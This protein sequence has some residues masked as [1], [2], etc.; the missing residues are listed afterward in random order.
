MGNYNPHAPYILGNEWVPIRQDDWQPD[1][2]SEFGYA[3]SI[4]HAVTPVTG[5]FYVNEVPQTRTNQA[6]DL[7]SVYPSGQ[8]TLT[9]P[10][11]VIHIPVS[12]VSSTGT[13]ISNVAVANLL[14]PSDGL[15][16]RFDTPS[17]GFTWLGLSF[18]VPAY[19]QQLYGKRILNVSFR[20]ALA[21]GVDAAESI[22]VEYGFAKGAFG[23]Q[24]NRFSLFEPLVVSSG[25]APLAIGK[26]DLTSINPFWD[27]S[28][29]PYQVHDVYP[30]RFQELSRFVFT[31]PPFSR[32]TIMMFNGLTG[33]SNAF[34]Y[35]ADLEVTYCEETRVLYGGTKTRSLQDSSGTS[36]EN[37]YEVGP[38][39]V[40]LRNSSALAFNTTSLAPGEYVT[41]LTHAQLPID[42]FR[43]IPT[44]AGIRELYQLPHQRG[45]QINQTLTPEAEFTSQATDF[46]PEITLHTSSA[47]VTGV[48][49]YGNQYDVPVYG[50]ITA[51]QEIEDGPVGA[52]QMYPQ[53][54]FYARRFG[55]TTVPLTLTDVATGTFTTSI[56][57]AD[58]DA[59]PEIVDGWKEVTLQFANPP[60]FSTAAGDV[61][62]RWSATGESAG[63]QWQVL[64]AGSRA[65]AAH[66]IGPAS[67]YAPQGN[68]VTLTW[69]SPAISGTA[70]DTLA[71]A[72]LIFAMNPPTV[73][74]FAV[75]TCEQELTVLD[76]A[77]PVRSCLPTSVYGNE[78]TWLPVS[79]AAIVSG[80]GYQLQRYDDVDGAWNTI[81]T[82]PDGTEFCDFEARVGV[83]T[84]YRVRTFNLLDFYGPWVTGSGTIASPG[85]DT[86][87]DGNSV[88]F[89]TSNHAPESA[90]AYVMSWEGKPIETFNFPE[91]D[92]V[93]LK[94]MFG[95]D[96]FTAFHPL[97][98]GG[99]QFT[100]IILVNNA[101]VT[102]PSLANFHNL[103][104]L[105]WA[106]LDYVC[107]RDELGNRWFANI[108]VPDGSVQMNRTIY[109]AQIQV[110]EVTN[111]PSPVVE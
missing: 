69:Q 105:A 18:N 30:W 78:L 16:V 8:E 59:L 97:E 32:M 37:N 100:R 81:Y 109:L 104:D 38:N 48:H 58:F 98:R 111:V 92:E 108:R 33:T 95:K 26:I 15:S 88:L 45:L 80:G 101:A 87:G 25:G 51:I 29:D 22:D 110:T 62:W 24:R 94:R 76:P 36:T 2:I 65:F 13:S 39:L 64:A 96:Y 6:I 79:A 56:S 83:Q 3:F 11:K 82:T 31:E 7:V 73:T 57:V 66:S 1:D 86:T 68:T 89:F 84:Y 85:G 19:A 106:D 74:G 49:P 4:S 75:G 53:V 28:R 71:D 70:E 93:Q 50:S 46:L 54:R 47:V 77:C 67:Y 44:L 102:L 34:L 63:N 20:Y 23:V 5:A 90:L 43:G 107:V 40:R 72:T 12:T 42:Q 52:S 9:G 17:D 91:A 14:N 60:S 41:T 55:A 21:G 10:V 35:F 27:P 103:R 99:E 61:D